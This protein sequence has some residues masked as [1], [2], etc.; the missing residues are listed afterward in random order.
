MNHK[1][2][3]VLSVV[4]VE[5]AAAL[6]AG[7]PSTTISWP[8]RPRHSRTSGHSWS[9]L[10]TSKELKRDKGRRQKGSGSRRDRGGR[11]R[12]KDKES[13]SNDSNDSDSDDSGSDSEDGGDGKGNG[14][15]KDDDRNKNKESDSPS[16][17]QQASTTVATRPSKTEINNPGDDG[18]TNT[19]I[20]VTTPSP[21]G[22]LPEVPE[23]KTLP[24]PLSLPPSKTA[25]SHSSS[26]PPTSTSTTS[27]TTG[28]GSE[29]T[30]DTNTGA[31]SNTSQSLPSA[32]SNDSP[33]VSP[34]T[35][36][37]P[38]RPP[39]QTAAIVG[40][41]LGGTALLLLI[42]LATFLFIRA[43]RKR[44]RPDSRP[45]TFY[46]DRMIKDIEE[47]LPTPLT[48]VS[49]PSSGSDS[50]SRTSLTDPLQVNFGGNPASGLGIPSRTSRQMQIE[51]KIFE[52]QS[53][54]ISLNRRT[55]S[56]RRSNV[57]SKKVRAQLIRD[58]I[59]RLE[60]LK[61]GDWAR[62]KSDEKPADM[63]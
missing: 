34:S 50:P 47:V 31:G 36:P 40:V 49:I 6:S 20:P 32:A 35:S 23:N 10:Q 38:R 25:S 2:S 37:A 9:A 43:R 18:P 7:F 63:P 26:H 24:F 12:D 22:P 42:L 44:T 14:E 33:Q 15:P 4:S 39:M 45:H 60:K 57:S 27:E 56:F 21:P 46:K 17:P 52:L 59:G 1:L 54:L 48:P 58:K 5:E 13:D 30:S 51:Q 62:E 11:R 61:D 28:T 41:V 53:S 55:I 29:G 16:F 8:A 3:L 19:G